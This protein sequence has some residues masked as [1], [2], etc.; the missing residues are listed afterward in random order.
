MYDTHTHPATDRKLEEVRREEE[1]FWKHLLTD[2]TENWEQSSQSSNNQSSY[3][4]RWVKLRLELRSIKVSS[5]TLQHWMSTTD[6]ANSAALWI[7]DQ[8]YW[9]DCVYNTKQHLHTLSQIPQI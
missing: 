4:Q 5:W 8:F 7:I 9:Q 3:K 6:A 1:T 2:K